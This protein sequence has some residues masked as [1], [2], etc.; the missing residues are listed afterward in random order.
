MDYLGKEWVFPQ[1]GLPLTAYC[2]RQYRGIVMVALRDP[3]L[4]LW[5]HARLAPFG[6]FSRYTQP[7]FA[8][9]QTPFV[10]ERPVTVRHF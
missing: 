4:Q 10:A 9:E 3:L 5:A 6:I 7:L 1:P 8:P 2:R